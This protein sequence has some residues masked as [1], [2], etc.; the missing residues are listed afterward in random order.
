M[1]P[2]HGQVQ[3]TPDGME[4]GNL[5]SSSPMFLHQSLSALLGV[6]NEA[7]K[8]TNKKPH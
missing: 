8:Q 1:V 4:G 6:L 2:Q 3:V 7:N 5:T